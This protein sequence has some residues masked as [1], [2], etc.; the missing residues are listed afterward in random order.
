MRLSVQCWTLREE[1]QADPAEACR[2]VAEIGYRYVELA[3]TYGLPPAEFAACLEDSGLAVSGMHV[4]LD[5]CEREIGRVLKEAELFGAPH[6][7]VPWVAPETYADGWD[8][9]ARRLEAVGAKVVEAGRRFSYHNHV[10]E[11]ARIGLTTGFDALMAA[12]DPK[13]VGA[14]IDVWWA[15]CGGEEPANLI[16]RHAGRTPLV[17][18]KDGTNCSDEIHVPAGEGTL[19]WASILQACAETGVEYGVVELDR[20]PRDPLECVR[21]SF[22][23]FDGRL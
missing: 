22:R 5:D 19:D 1:F 7:T 3:G 6:I 17:H 2:K 21:S 9:L 4:G 11:F 16:W 8:R 13:L 12:A 10:F 18:L 20:C 23:F 15:R 14:E